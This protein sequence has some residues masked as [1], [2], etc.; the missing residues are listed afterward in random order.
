MTVRVHAAAFAIFSLFP[1]SVLAQ[2]TV[3]APSN[4]DGPAAPIDASGVSAGSN[5]STSAVYVPPFGAPWVGRD[6]NANLPS[7]SRPS[8]NASSSADSFDLGQSESGDG[9][10]RGGKG[11]I[12]I[13]RRGRA[14]AMQVPEVY[15]VKRGD[16][17][18]DISDHYFEN[19]WQWPKLWSLNPEVRNPNWI[20]PGDQLRLRRDGSAARG[21]GSDNGA[22]RG[23][24]LGLGNGAGSPSGTHG[25][26]KA[27]TLFLRDEAFIGDPSKD[28]W[29]EVVGA[30]EEQMLLSRGNHVYIDMRSGV[31]PKIGQEITLFEPLRKPEP[32]EGARTP[33]GE[34]VKIK[35]TVKITEFDPKRKVASAEIVEAVDTIERGVKIGDVE[36][37][38]RIVAPTTSTKTVW[39]HVLTSVHPHVYMG[40]NQLVF[41]DRGSEDGLA[42]GNR[43]LV[44][45]QGDSWRRSLATTTSSARDSLRIDSPKPA[46]VRTTTLR[47]DDKDFPE[48]II[49]ELRVLQVSR[50]SASALVAESQREI[51]VGDRA[52][53]REG[54]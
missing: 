22:G 47:R 26:V 2:P 13:T 14:A 15:L 21:S 10:V 27:D 46:E 51:V 3:P 45:R 16:T 38:Y 41:I 44:V 42:I 39:A 25:P 8:S 12:A 7:S 24:R 23:G 20:Y 53:A 36:R 54:Y 18:W 6:P 17:L 49:G 32:V 1:Y 11:S 50:Y 43:L 33:P 37:R 35:G 29:G 9:T 31:E 52:V 28:T 19:P 48:E 4:A 34:I 40:Q 5:A 30:R